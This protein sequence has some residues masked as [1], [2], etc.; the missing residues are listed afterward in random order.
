[1]NLAETAY[2]MPTGMLLHE[3]GRQVAMAELVRDGWQQVLYERGS[4]FLLLVWAERTCGVT[5][6]WGLSSFCAE[7][8]HKCRAAGVCVYAPPN[9]GVSPSP[10]GWPSISEDEE[11]VRAAIQAAQLVPNRDSD[12]Y[13]A[14]A[15]LVTRAHGMGGNA[16]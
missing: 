4:W 9:A 15:R 11:T 5:T 3:A 10:S 8:G 7:V 16:K 1:M 2:D 14:L 6:C 12:A 13:E